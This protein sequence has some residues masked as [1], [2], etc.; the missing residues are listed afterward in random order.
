M[1]DEP[2]DALGKR[3]L[4]VEQQIQEQ[5]GD[6]LTVG[7]MKGLFT[8]MNEGRLSQA[9]VIEKLS[10]ANAAQELVYEA[11]GSVD[12]PTWRKIRDNEPRRKARIEEAKR[13]NER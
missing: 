3:A 7:I 8:R 4:Q 11:L 5:Y 6:N 9:D 10:H 2:S 1:S 12:E 13:I